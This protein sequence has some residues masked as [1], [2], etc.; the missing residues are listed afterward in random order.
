MRVRFPSPALDG[1]L[2]PVE[3][4][5]TALRTT[6]RA[7]SLRVSRTRDGRPVAE[8]LAWFTAGA[9]GLARQMTLN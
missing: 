6:R 7:E 8:A 3:L 2:G 4:T 5:V 1:P 9:D